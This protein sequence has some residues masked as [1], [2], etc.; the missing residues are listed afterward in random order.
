MR[1]ADAEPIRRQRVVLPQLGRRGAAP[2]EITVGAESPAGP[3]RPR[4]LPPDSRPGKRRCEPA[5]ASPFRGQGMCAC[6]RGPR[7]ALV[8]SVRT[9]IP[10][11]SPGVV[12]V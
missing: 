3:L 6:V 7:A 4:V 8:V 11:P 1:G 5:T 2:G 9:L 10:L 12:G